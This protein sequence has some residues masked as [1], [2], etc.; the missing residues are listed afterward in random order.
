M[1]TSTEHHFAPTTHDSHDEHAHGTRYYVVIAAI[2]AT[3]TAL[4]TSTYWIDFGPLFMPL[5]LTLMAVKFFMVVLFFMH[6]KDDAKLFSWLF[7]A[8]LFLALGVYI[9]AALTF[10][11]FE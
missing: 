5:L 8:G 2:L 11:F 9:A 7:Y 10:R 3:I 1:N 4:E 6:L